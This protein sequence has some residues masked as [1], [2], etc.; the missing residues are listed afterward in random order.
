MPPPPVHAAA[1]AGAPLAPLWNERRATRAHER[2]IG[3]LNCGVR[4]SDVH[5]ARG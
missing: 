5:Q 4:D 3:L 2:L 1:T